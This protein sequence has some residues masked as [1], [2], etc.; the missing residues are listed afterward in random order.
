MDLILS[1]SNVKSFN[2]VKEHKGDLYNMWKALSEEFEPQ[3]EILLI[4]LLSEF[5]GNKLTDPKSNVTEWMS[6]LELQHQRLKAMGH[7]ITDNHLIMHILVNLPKRVY[8]YDD[9]AVPGI[10]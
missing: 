5:N 3:T 8:C 4:E 2:L 10:W 6:M 9:G 1:M 7:D